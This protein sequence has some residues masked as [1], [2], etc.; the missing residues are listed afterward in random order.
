[1][2]ANLVRLFCAMLI[3]FPVAIGGFLEDAMGFAVSL[4][5]VKTSSVHCGLLLDGG[6]NQA[7]IDGVATCSIKIHEVSR[8]CRNKAG[9]AGNSVSENFAEQPVILTGIVGSLATKTSNGPISEDIVFTD[10]ELL[11]IIQQAN[12]AFSL[13]PKVVCPSANWKVEWAI[14]RMDLETTISTVAVRCKDTVLGNGKCSDFDGDGVVGN[15]PDDAFTPFPHYR[16][17]NAHFISC[18]PAISTLVY[19]FLDAE[20]NINPNDLAEGKVDECL[21]FKDWKVIANSPFDG[22]GGAGDGG[23]A[24]RL[25]S[26]LGSSYSCLCSDHG[27]ESGHWGDP[28]AYQQFVGAATPADPECTGEVQVMQTEP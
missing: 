21:M 12:P 22:P 14:T 10:L 6:G 24:I 11:Q 17:P 28:K 8:Q 13:D 5:G 16:D 20:G 3:A 26:Q 18:N 2:L 23:C 27:F 4:K 15:D 25:G 19:A 7:K 9:K 1:M